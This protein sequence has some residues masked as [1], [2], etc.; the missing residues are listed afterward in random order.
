[1]DVESTLTG[2]SSTDYGT[3]HWLFQIIPPLLMLCVLFATAEATFL[4]FLVGI[5]ALPFLISVISIIVKLI[6]F[7][8]RKYYLLRPSLTITIFILLV[9][10]ANWTYKIALDQTID[11]GKMIHRQCNENSV[12]PDNPVGWQREGSITRKNNLG[13]WLKYP[14]SYYKDKK[15]GFVISL[16]RGPDLGHDIRGGVDLPFTVDQHL[17]R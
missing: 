14:A 5:L 1:M 12:C 16:Y 6:K 17:D 13:F 8:K 3:K 4:V 11:E 15:G 9:I 2:K 10:F 7:S